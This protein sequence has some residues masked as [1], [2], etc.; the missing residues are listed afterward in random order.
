MFAN[1]GTACRA[2]HHTNQVD[3]SKGVIRSWPGLKAFWP[4]RTFLLISLILP[5]NWLKL[6]WSAFA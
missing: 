2:K 5:S 4:I 1:K 6:R 3:R